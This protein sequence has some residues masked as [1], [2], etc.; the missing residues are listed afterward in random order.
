MSQRVKTPLLLHTCLTVTPYIPSTTTTPLPL[1]DG[2]ET[3]EPT[4]DVE[5]AIVTCLGH[6]KSFL[7]GK[8]P[9]PLPATSSSSEAVGDIDV[10]Q[11]Q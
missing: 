5:I 1:D 8:E 3:E 6:K 11:V 9:P 2:N 10:A 7:L 4:H